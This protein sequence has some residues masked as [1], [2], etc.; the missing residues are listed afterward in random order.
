ML[1]W[2]LIQ[3]GL[4]IFWYAIAFFVIR[5]KSWKMSFPINPSLFSK[6]IITRVVPF[7]WGL[8][9]FIYGIIIVLQNF[10]KQKLLIPI[11]FLT[12]FPLSIF[13][14]IGVSAWRKS[15]TDDKREKSEEELINTKK[16][17]F[18]QWTNQFGFLNE[19]MIEMRLYI[20]KGK[21]VGRIGIRGLSESQ[22]DELAQ[23]K[24]ELP[25]GLFLELVGYKHNNFNN[26]DHYH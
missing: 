25:E 10:D 17:E 15:V 2:F 9:S 16:K 14:I 20:S 18:I 23:H 6:I 1:R 26:N 8:S 7:F 13:V 11:M 3:V 22:L 4:L 12:V 5:L 19:N 24:D 21:P